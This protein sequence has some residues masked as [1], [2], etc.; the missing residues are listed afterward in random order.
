MPWPMLGSL[1]LTC[2][3]QPYVA[4]RLLPFWLFDKNTPKMLENVPTSLALTWFTETT[5]RLWHVENTQSLTHVTYFSMVR[6]LR[7]RPSEDLNQ[8]SS[9]FSVP[10][11]KWCWLSTDAMLL[12]CERSNC[13]I[14]RERVLICKCARNDLYW[15][16]C[17][18][19]STCA[20]KNSPQT[21]T[22]R[23]E[24]S[25]G[26]V[27]YTNSGVYRYHWRVWCEVKECKL[28]SGYCFVVCAHVIRNLGG[29]S[30]QTALRPANRYEIDC[31]WQ[32]VEVH[33]L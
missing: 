16:T 23:S 21:N 22:N 33:W 26:L 30:G 13:M 27:V 7:S 20:A 28:L 2:S 4:T 11:K 5:Y 24:C 9:N 18:V 3:S 14:L 12:Q 29:P 10:S 1:T 8:T 25:R 6:R 17:F 32:A 31:V 19:H 15:N